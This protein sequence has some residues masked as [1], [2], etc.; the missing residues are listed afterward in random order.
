MYVCMYVYVCMVC[1]YVCMYGMY[2]CMV[3]VYV[4]MYGMY[5]CIYG[6]YVCMVCVYVW[7]VCMYVI[8]LQGGKYERDWTS[9]LLGC[10][11]TSM[12]DSL[13]WPGSSLDGFHSLHLGKIGG[14]SVPT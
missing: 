12:V 9:I 8:I 6:M 1:M 13:I 10:T 5:V 14:R 11:L 2:V 7:Y 3:C 4:C